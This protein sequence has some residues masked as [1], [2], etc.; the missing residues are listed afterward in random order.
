MN[1]T[2]IQQ[3]LAPDITV[4]YEKNSASTMLDAKNYPAP[5]LVVA[6]NQA[7]AHGRFKRPFFTQAHHGIYLSLKIAGPKKNNDQPGA[8]NTPAPLYTE[9]AA[10][11]LCEAIE[12]LTNLQPTIKW[13]ND[14]YLDGKKIAGILTQAQFSAD[15]PTIETLTLGLGLNF[16]IPQNDFPIDLQAKV[17]SLFSQS[18]A[19]ITQEQLIIAFV[20]TF[21]QKV[22]LPNRELLDAYKRR[23][24]F[25]G[26][27][28]TYVFNGVA[29]TG[30]AQDIAEDGALVVRRPD[31][32]TQHLHSGEI[33]LT[34]F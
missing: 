8:A 13:V 16:D 9:A 6:P 30:L 12:S 4:V 31:G 27:P 21:F 10:V 19:T 28:V 3:A 7:A 11:A 34:Q 14:V 5:V 26:R 23:L 25:L 17:T 1:I 29:T 22:A 20:T 32:T 24:F 15:Q 33:S 2:L 18:P